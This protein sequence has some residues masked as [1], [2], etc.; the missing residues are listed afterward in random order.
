MKRAIVIAVGLSVFA[1]APRPELSISVNGKRNP[2][3]RKGGPVLV[4][5]V[6]MHSGRLVQ[7]G[8]V[9]ELRV[10]PAAAAWYD[11]IRLRVKDGQG[12][13]KSW[14]ASL[15]SRPEL[16]ALALG[17]RA[18]AALE[19][20]MDETASSLFEAGEYRIEA[21]L[22][23][24]GSTSGWNGVAVS[25]PAI[26]KIVEPAE[27]TDSQRVSEALLRT[28]LSLRTGATDEAKKAVDA[29]LV[30]QPASIRALQLRAEIFE[31]EGDL[32]RALVFANRALAAARIKYTE[33][34]QLGSLLQL[35]DRMY[36]KLLE[37]AAPAASALP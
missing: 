6:I 33:I 28:V 2:E 26:L 1:Q 21:V 20:T 32:H 5:A 34:G 7:T 25:P 9:P 8:N 17:H 36:G 16:P 24:T 18:W 27:L 19:W 11:A 15:V 31:K 30:E 12:A 10:A 23:V 29:L 22:E 37:K 14:N 3:A 13:E 35:R 4:R